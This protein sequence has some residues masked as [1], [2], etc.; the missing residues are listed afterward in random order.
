MTTVLPGAEGMGKFMQIINDKYPIK[1]ERIKKIDDDKFEAGTGNEIVFIEKI[2]DCRARAIFLNGLY[3]YIKVKGF[4]DIIEINESSPGEY[5]TDL[6]GGFY[7][8]YRS[9][10][11]SSGSME[12][13]EESI[14][15]T[16]ARFHRY[17]EGYIPPTG[18]KYKSGWGRC[19]DKFS[20]GLRNIKKY[21]DNIRSK[22]IRPPFETLFLR[23]CDKFICMME[24]AL[25]TLYNKGYLDVVEASMK[26]HQICLCN[27]KRSNWV[28]S[29]QDIFIKSIDKCRYDIPEY[30]IALFFKETIKSKSW[31]YQERVENLIDI[32]N[33]EN[34]LNEYSIDI[35][36]AFLLYPEDYLKTCINYSKKGFASAD[37]IYIS[38]LHEAEALEDGKNKIV[39][40]LG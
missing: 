2:I 19:I 11:G 5:Y 35:I 16:I 18:S 24:E 32:Y 3:Q 7:I 29:G 36:K 26:K 4:T 20:E 13:Y 10:Y 12:G 30:D 14:M 17:S 38:K 39:E 27:L 21:K 37:S 22:D 15:R 25:D 1:I 33:S 34:R 28:F 8:V 9:G 31:I 40:M 6:D 23:N